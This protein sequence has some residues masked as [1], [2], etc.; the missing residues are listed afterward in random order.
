MYKPSCVVFAQCAF[1]AC[2]PGAGAAPAENLTAPPAPVDERVTLR[3]GA[4][5]P[6]E[7]LD[8]PQKIVF[9]K[10]EASDPKTILTNFL[11]SD[12]GISLLTMGMGSQMLRW[13][14]YMGQTFAQVASLGKSLVARHGAETNGFEYDT[15]P[16]LTSTVTARAEKAQVVIPLNRYMVSAA[17]DSSGIQPILVRLDPNVNN[18]A[19]LIS[20][21]KVSLKEQ[22][23]GRF[24]LKPTVA[25]EEKEVRQTSV[26]VEVER[27]PGNILSVTT[28]GPLA[29]G[30]YALVL[31]GKSV[32]GGYTDNVPLRPTPID[33][34]AARNPK[35][36]PPPSAFS[37]LRRMRPGGPSPTDG[38]SD[39]QP[40]MA[41][42]LA[43][44]FR[45]FPQ[46]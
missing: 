35:Q 40:S 45:V 4:G 17:F 16:G 5:V 38:P 14:P 29:A 42:F 24:D 1:L 31:R 23:N 20:S 33:A 28:A 21:R 13:N 26:P 2:A 10:T 22:R 6:V 39:P 37:V 7:L 27:M 41:G 25:R 30:E 8:H 44:D 43:W 19:R 3:Q 46:N 12:V 9:V 18:Q 32:A 11:F 36:G 34:G 15:L